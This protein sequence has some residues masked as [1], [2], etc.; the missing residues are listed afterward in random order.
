MEVFMELYELK[1]YIDKNYEKVKDLWRL[2]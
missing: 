1:K 2:L